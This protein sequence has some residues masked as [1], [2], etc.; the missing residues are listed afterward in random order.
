MTGTASAP[1]ELVVGEPSDRFRTGPG[2]R[3]EGPEVAVAALGLQHNCRRSALSQMRQR[4]VSQSKFSVAALEVAKN[5]HRTMT[6]TALNE[7]MK[8]LPRSRVLQVWDG[9]LKYPTRGTP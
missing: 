1:V 4:R 8:T 9:C 7:P 2:V 6:R 5:D 3:A